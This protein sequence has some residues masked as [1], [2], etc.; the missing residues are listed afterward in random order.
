MAR[1]PILERPG[2][3][4]FKPQLERA[5]DYIESLSGGGGPVAWDDVT[6]K[7]STFAP[8]AHTHTWGE[9]TSVPAAIS[10]TTAS[11]TTAQETKLAGIATGATANATDA[12]LRDRATHT[13]TQAAGTITGLAAVATS[14]AYG[15]L[16]GLPSLFDGAYASLSGVPATFAPSAHGHVIADTAGLQT[17]LDGKAATSHSHI[18]ADVTGLQTALDGK[19][20]SGSYAAAS[21]THPLSDL[22][23][24]GA[25]SGQVAAWNG[26][27]WAPATVSGG[28]G[29]T[30]ATRILNATQAMVNS[31]IVQNWFTTA[32]GLALLA[33]STYEFEATFFSLNGSTSH[34]LN[35]QFA[36]LAGATIQWNSI[37][38]KGVATTAAT[39]HRSVGTNTFATNR[40]VTSANTVAGNR[41]RVWGTVRTGAAGTLIPRVAQTAASGS[42]TVQPGTFF[43]ARR[44]GADTLT[45]TGEWS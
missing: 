6:G 9:V 26:S 11:F 44:I 23:Q 35:M 30:W 2:S 45:N 42:F 40:L 43:K 17:A 29:A 39:A 16:T 28:G 24:S 33:N 4:L 14:G 5:L 15:D 38:T 34:G 1:P 27:A 21:H 25:T 19:Q 7:P 8:S 41:V 20:A 31:T 3:A 37:G 32:G 13:G 10:G 18:I 12:A 22:T 36:A